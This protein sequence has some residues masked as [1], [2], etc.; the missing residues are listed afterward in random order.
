[1]TATKVPPVIEIRDPALDG[2]EIARR[3]QQQ[4]ER[5]RAE[6]RYDPDLSRRGPPSLRPDR[7]LPAEPSVMAEFPG[8]R[9]SLAELVAHS[10]LHEPAFAS[11]APLIGPLIVAVRRAWNWMSTKWYVRPILAQQSEVNE[12]TASAL[13][14]LAQWHEM[15]SRDL[16]RLEAQVAALEARLARLENKEEP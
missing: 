2:A 11:N 8:L 16:R 10:R 14:D 6:G 9:E 12:R 7:P 15:D 5:R 1:M 3:V 13:G 4:V